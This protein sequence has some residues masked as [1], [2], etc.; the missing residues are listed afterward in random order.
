MKQLIITP[1]TLQTLILLGASR[2]VSISATCAG[3]SA[4]SSDMKALAS[5]S[6][7]AEGS[8]PYERIELAEE[9]RPFA[10]VKPALRASV[11]D[12]RTI[13]QSM[14]SDTASFAIEPLEIVG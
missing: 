13:M 4:R 3:A 14:E 8:A 9:S 1:R 11:V 7:L 12:Q 6:R 10:R 2:V 5:H